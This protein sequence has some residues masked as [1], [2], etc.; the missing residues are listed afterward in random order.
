MIPTTEAI[1]F[2]AALQ[3]KFGAI[4]MASGWNPDYIVT[5]EALNRFDRIVIQSGGVTGQRSVHAFV[6]R[7]TGDLIKSGGWKAPQKEKDGLAARY[8]LV[9]EFDLAVEHADPYGS[10]LY[11][12]ARQKKEAAAAAS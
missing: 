2:A 3:E 1:K 11:K 10:Y 7:A 9:T 5:V 12:G 8:N 4:R 6:D